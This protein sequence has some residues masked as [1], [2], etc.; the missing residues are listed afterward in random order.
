MKEHSKDRQSDVVPDDAT[1]LHM[2][3]DSVNIMGKLDDMEVHADM[4]PSA[5]S[6]RKP[7]GIRRYS[8]DSPVKGLDPDAIPHSVRLR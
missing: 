7:N 3:K 2:I 5:T 6:A 8:E 1:L 4:S